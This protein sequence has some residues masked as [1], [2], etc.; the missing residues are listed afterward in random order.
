MPWRDKPGMRH[1]SSR[2]MKKTPTLRRFSNANARRSLLW[3][4][5]RMSTLKAPE[6]P[7]DFELIEPSKSSYYL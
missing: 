2:E 6:T 7:G 5:G 1:F 4:T 3:T